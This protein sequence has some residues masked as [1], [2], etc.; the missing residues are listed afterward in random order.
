M[1]RLRHLAIAAD[2]PDATTRFY[3]DVFDFRHVRRLDASWGHG[4]V[5]TDGT[6]SVSILKY[7]DPK[8]AGVDEL[9]SLGGL[10]HIG[11]EVDDFG[12]MGPRINAAGAR[13]RA[14][15]SEAL[16]VPPHARVEEYEGPDGVVFD[17]GSIG[18]WDSA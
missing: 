11:F 14:D 10:H 1:A 17:L 4:H 6:M 9:G 15:I 5:I 12:A 18:L 13:R 3:I 8:A 16:G 2:D 7:T